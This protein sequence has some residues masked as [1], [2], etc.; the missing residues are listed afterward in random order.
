MRRAD[1]LFDILQ[2][3]RVAVRP[4]TAATIA[5]RLE[6]TV[7]TIYRDIATLQARRIPIE[8]APGIGYVLR[9]GFDL[10]PLMFTS[11]EI[12]AIAVGARLVRRLR[13]PGLQNAANSVLAKVTTVLPEALRGGVTA[14]PFF[15][16]PGDAE[17][18]KG[19]DL[20]KLR[21][22][23]RETVK[24]RITYADAQGQNTQRTVWPVAMAYYVDV[25]LLGA[26][27]ELRSDFR[28]FRVERII[29]CAILDDRF[30]TEGGKLM[31]RWF[32]LQSQPTTTE[33]P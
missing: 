17:T 25:T 2:T 12:D 26:W 6:V 19:V 10:P 8:G 7:R 33:T 4:M 11:D 9:R 3:L 31:Q 24:L 28:H 5:E 27:C 29:T 18:P 1:R 21:H 14:A 16:S 20:A 30:P 15:V 32:A 22:A 23:I 13:D